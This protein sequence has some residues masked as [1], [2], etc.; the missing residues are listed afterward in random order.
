MCFERRRR[1]AI[2]V[3]TQNVDKAGSRKPFSLFDQPNLRSK[4]P[5]AF[6][7][8]CSRPR[9]Q[10]EFV[11]D[12]HLPLGRNRRSLLSESHAWLV[13]QRRCRNFSIGEKKI[14]S[15]SKPITTITIMI[16]MTCSIAL[17]SRP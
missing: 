9:V 16:P 5:D 14:L 13:P 8:L 1:T 3:G 17:S 12:A 6:D 10:S 11:G 7:E 2:E 15:A 4:A